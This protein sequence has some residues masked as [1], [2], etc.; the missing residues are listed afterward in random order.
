MKVRQDQRGFVLSGAALLLVLPAMM[1]AASC[2]AV[3]E[4]GGEAAALQASADKV[5]YTGKDIERVI[6]DLWY[7]NILVDNETNA[8]EK[9]DNLA[10]NYRV[11]T[12]LLVDITPTWMLWT[13]VAGEDRYGGSEYCKIEHVAPGNWRYYFEDSNDF[14]FDEPIL[15]VEKLDANLSITLEY[16]NGLVFSGSDIY[17]NYSDDP[18]WGTGSPI[19]GNK[20]IEGVVQLR[21]SVYVRDPRGAAQYSSTLELG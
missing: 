4:M 5:F 2:F 8:N 9:F 16:Y 3:I 6:W 14:D 1:I 17:Y 18:L 15:A 11:T 20:V 12:G 7:E 19:G 10:E 21:V 13:R